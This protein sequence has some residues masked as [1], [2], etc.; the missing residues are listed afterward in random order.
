[1]TEFRSW[2]DSLAKPSWT[3]E[4]STIG[5]VWTVLYPIIFVTFAIAVFK[6]VR[7]EVPRA[8]IAAVAI[9]TVANLAF[10]PLQFGLRNLWLAWADILIV[11]ATI[12]W[13]MVL[14]WQP[15]ARWLA[16]M[17]VPYLTW[18]GI[19][20]TLQTAITFGNR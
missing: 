2:Y 11:L 16:L 15:G 14:L 19:A 5:L 7:G 3:P 9:N 6:A 13:L 18:V 8:V 10:T 20:T 1:M 12:V 17:L 4:P